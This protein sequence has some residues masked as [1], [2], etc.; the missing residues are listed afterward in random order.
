MALQAE[1]T[2]AT[3]LV[4]YDKNTC[5]QCQAWL[6]APDWSEFLNERCVRHARSCESCGYDFETV[7]FFPV[8]QAAAA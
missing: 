1:T 5:Q 4:T 8:P 7:V 3:R 2:V 6:L